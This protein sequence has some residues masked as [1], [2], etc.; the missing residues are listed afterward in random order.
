MVL[1]Y[2]EILGERMNGVYTYSL[3]ILFYPVIWSCHLRACLWKIQ[4]NYKIHRYI[5]LKNIAAGLWAQGCALTLTNVFFC[6]AAFE[7]K[8]MVGLGL[9]ILHQIFESIGLAVVAGFY[10]TTGK[11]WKNLRP[12]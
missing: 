10:K 6:F 2:L 11:L 1:I 3:Y 12:F 4:R 8:V 9:G 7:R 5:N